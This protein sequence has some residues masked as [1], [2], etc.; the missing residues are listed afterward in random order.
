M[1]DEVREFVEQRTGEPANLPPLESQREHAL[2]EQIH[3]QTIPQGLV[4]P[5]PRPEPPTVHYTELPDGSPDS[6]IAGEWNLYRREV[7]RLLAEG[8]ENKWAL[9]KG[10]EIV[11]IWDTEKEARAVALRKYLM[12]PCLIH[13]VRSREPVLRGPTRLWLWQ[14]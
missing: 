3:R 14:N 10:D 5:L 1:N 13:Q 7:G 4:Q 9:I 2:V 8:H 12:K 11:G 6:P